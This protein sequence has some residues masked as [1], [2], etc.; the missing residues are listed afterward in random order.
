MELDR[1]EDLQ[2]TGPDWSVSR[3]QTIMQCGKKYE[4]KYILKTPEQKTPP[5]AFGSAIHSVIETLHKEN[6]WDDGYVQRLWSDEWYAAQEGIDWDATSYRK[7]TYDTKGVKILDSYIAKHKDDEWIFL[8]AKFRFRPTAGLP[9]L[10]GTYDKVQRLREHPDVPPQY[11]GRIAVIDY[12]TSK[13][14]PDPTLLSVDPQLS[15]YHK[16]FPQV[17]KDL[18]LESD[19]NP[20]LGLHHLPTD[21]IYWCEPT[22]ETFKQVE[23]MLHKGIKR[24]KN[25]EWERNISWQCK[26][27]AYKKE[28]L[29]GIGAP[30]I[31]V[32]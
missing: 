25:K 21:T 17:Y 27:C 15:I 16:A 22:E 19:L 30:P 29:S 1:L 7:S 13:N 11:V 23:V 32:S 9:F 24:V 10:R 26:F 28:C 3:L 5:L 20:I 8:E 12:K 14:P 31:T 18:L 6:K 4:Y 2:D